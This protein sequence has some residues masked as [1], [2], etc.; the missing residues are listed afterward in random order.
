MKNWNKYKPPKPIDSSEWPENRRLRQIDK[1]PNFDHL[2]GKPHMPKTLK[3]IRGP[4]LV[5]TELLYKGYGV[6]VH[7]V[8]NLCVTTHNLCGILVFSMFVCVVN[9]VCTKFLKD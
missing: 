2:K 5:H 3:L 8:F 6:K 4:E 7:I 9:C 1:T